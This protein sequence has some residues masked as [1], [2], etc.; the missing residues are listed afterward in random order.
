MFFEAL[1]RQRAK[2]VDVHLRTGDAD[3][4]QIERAAAD[5]RLE[6]REDLLPREVACGAEENQGIRLTTRHCGAP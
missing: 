3:D 1:A 4:R 2:P 5:Q 6:G